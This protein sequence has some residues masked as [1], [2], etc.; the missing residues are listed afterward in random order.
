VLGL[1]AAPSRWEELDA[2]FLDLMCADEDLLCAE[3]DAIIA[4]CWGSRMHRP[5]PAVCVAA[6]QLVRGARTTRRSRTAGLRRVSTADSRARQ[7]SPP[8]QLGSAIWKRGDAA[9]E[10]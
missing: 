8:S 5:R 1:A 3:F 10:T 4:A 7:R 9:R 2:Q 6:W